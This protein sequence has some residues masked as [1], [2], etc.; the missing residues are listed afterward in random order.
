MRVIG[1]N[2]AVLSSFFDSTKAQLGNQSRILYIFFN[3]K[4]TITEKSQIFDIN[5]ILGVL[6]FFFV[7]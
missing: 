3:N 6:T 1:A 5:H 7:V 4:K 2:F